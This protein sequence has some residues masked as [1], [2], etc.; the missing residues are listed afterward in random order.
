MEE[1]S[2]LLRMK[3]HKRLA[4]NDDLAERIL[5]YDYVANTPSLDLIFLETR[6]KQNDDSEVWP[7]YSILLGC[8]KTDNPWEDTVLLLDSISLWMNDF[9]DCNEIGIQELDTTRDGYNYILMYIIGNE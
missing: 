6:F 9:E 7:E 2:R 5:R 1:I 8:R 4:V 3:G